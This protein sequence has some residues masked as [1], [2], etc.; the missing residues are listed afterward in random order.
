MIS[1]TVKA[2]KP[3]NI[4]VMKFLYNATARSDSFANMVAYFHTQLPHLSESGIYGYYFVDSIGQQE[5]YSGGDGGALLGSDYHGD[6]AKILYGGM[7][8]PTTT[9]NIHG[10]FVAPELTAQQM[11]SL[12]EPM[13]SRLR[14]LGPESQDRQPIITQSQ[15]EDGGDF[16]KYWHQ[17]VVA[18]SGGFPIRIGSRLLG[19]DS[20]L[21]DFNELK[22]AL[23][24]STPLPFHINGHLVA[25]AP[26]AQR[27]TGGVAGGS[28]AVLP[29][30]RTTYTHVVL[31]RF[32]TPLNT[33]EEVALTT[34]I[35]DSG[36]VA[37]RELSPNTGEYMNEADPTEPDWQQSQYGENYPRLLQIKQKYDPHG[38]F[39]CKHCVGSELWETRGPYGIENGVGQNKVR[40]CWRGASK[41]A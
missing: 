6:L 10:L 31:S 7:P 29:A 37:L 21:G 3:V 36:E 34:E 41:K 18:Q 30:W 40:L 24:K 39:W 9:G 13:E 5:P 17:H 32:W 16:M 15:F 11:K 8:L 25:P 22:Y 2:Y 20:L 26:N 19:N 38:V 12:I 27:P 28:N 14:E 23:N 4:A 1:I 33:T 35:R